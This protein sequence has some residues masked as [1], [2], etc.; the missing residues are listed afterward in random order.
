MSGS[1]KM[2]DVT[3]VGRSNK[4]TTQG[5]FALAIR[6]NIGTCSARAIGPS[7]LES[8]SH[9]T[10]IGAEFRCAIALLGRARLFNREAYSYFDALCDDDPP[11]EPA[12]EQ[13]PP[14]TAANIFRHH[15]VAVAFRADATKTIVAMENKVHNLEAAI[16]HTFLTARIAQRRV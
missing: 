16:L 11:E 4:M 3:R 15:I 13:A 8:T 2:M 6:K 1:G 12:L 7:L 9:S 14:P 10:A 5:A